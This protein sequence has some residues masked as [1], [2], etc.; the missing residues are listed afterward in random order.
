MYLVEKHIIKQNHKYYDECDKLS[1]FSKNLYNAS[2]YSI[3][4]HFFETENY[5]N[6][7]KN[8]H[9]VKS[10]TDYKALPAKVSNQVIKLVDQNFKSFFTLL[11]KKMPDS[12]IN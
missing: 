10:S 11:K 5:L 2:L 6:Y 1:F 12:L 7:V 9:I 4:Q 3:R 8:Y